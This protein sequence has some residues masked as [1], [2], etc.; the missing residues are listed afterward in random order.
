MKDFDFL[1]NHRGQFCEVNSI[2]HVHVFF[3]V[4]ALLEVLDDSGSDARV[5]AE[6]KGSK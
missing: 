6:V 3:G 4:D 5:V 2:D 1:I